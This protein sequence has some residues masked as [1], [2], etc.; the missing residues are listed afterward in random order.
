MLNKEICKRCINETNAKISIKNAWSSWGNMEWSKRK[1]WCPNKWMD[2]K[3]VMD[4]VISIERGNPPNSC[5]YILEHMML[6]ER[7]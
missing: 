3:D 6:S 7:R 1:V 4:G 5:P 2:S